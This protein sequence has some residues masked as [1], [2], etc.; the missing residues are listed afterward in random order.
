MVATDGTLTIG[1]LTVRP[2]GYSL[3]TI[4]GLQSWKLII[5]REPDLRGPFEYN[6][7]KDLGRVDMSVA[8]SA[9]TVEQLTISIDKTGDTTAVLSIAWENT[10]AS[11]P[12]SVTPREPG[13]ALPI[14]PP[15]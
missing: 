1:N 9:Q 7:K 15:R 10:V 11:V 13:N 14:S 3:F 12:I 8:T 4:P 5:N 2:G 6:R